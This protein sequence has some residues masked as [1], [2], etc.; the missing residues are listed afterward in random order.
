MTT[1]TTTAT[2][3]LTR[4]ELA[5]RWKI[6]VQTLA[7]WA[8]SGKS[9]PQYGPAFTKLGRH[10]RYRLADI[11]AWEAAQEQAPTEPHGGDAA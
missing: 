6:P 10:V 2:V 4:A 9:G 11:E 3:W 8:A 1:P 5:A 7:G